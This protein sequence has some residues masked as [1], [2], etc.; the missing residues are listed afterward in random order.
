M[1]LLF[2]FGQFCPCVIQC[3][4]WPN[5]IEQTCFCFLLRIWI[6]VCALASTHSAQHCP[7]LVTKLDMKFGLKFFGFRRLVLSPALN[8]TIYFEWRIFL[9]SFCVRHHKHFLQLKDNFMKQL[10]GRSTGL[11]W[12]LH[13]LSIYCSLWNHCLL[14]SCSGILFFFFF[15]FLAKLGWARLHTVL[16]SVSEFD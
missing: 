8:K 1:Q 12:F 6:G 16:P 14:F 15:L 4:V 2:L 11:E 9:S 13:Y 7:L 10:C 5:P 3:T